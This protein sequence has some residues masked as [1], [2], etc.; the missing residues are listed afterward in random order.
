[1]SVCGLTT[2]L[3]GF[4]FYRFERRQ[5]ENTRNL[6]QA[7]EKLEKEV[8]ERERY[9]TAL[10]NNE[11]E[12]RILFENMEQ[13]VVVQTSETEIISVNPAAEKILGLSKDQ[14]MGRTSFDPRWKAMRENYTDLPGDEHPVSLALR[15]G[16]PVRNMVMGVFNPHLEETRWIMVNATPLFKNGE[17]KPYQV[18]ATFHDI[19]DRKRAE[20]A[21]QESEKRFALFMDH[22]PGVAFIKDS[23]GRYVFLNK[24]L[25]EMPDNIRSAWYGKTNGDLFP[26]DIAKALMKTDQYVLSDQI[27]IQ[28]EEQAGGRVWLSTK[29]PIVSK[30][31]PDM[32]GGISLDITDRKRAEEDR[33]KLEAQLLH[34]QKM[35]ALGELVGGISHDFNNMLQV[36]IGYIQILLMDKDTEH[37]E[38]SPLYEV[39][40]AALSTRKLIRQLMT[41]SRQ[42]ISQLQPVDINYEI[43]KVKTLLERTIPK[44]ID[45][46]LHLEEDVWPINGDPTQLEQVLV[47][48]SINARDAMPEGGQLIFETANVALDEEYCRTHLGTTP[49]DHVLVSVTDSGRGMEK[50]VMSRIF[51]PFFTTKEKERGTGLGLAM[52]FGIVKSHDGEIMCYSEPGHGTTFKIYFPAAE[53]EDHG[54]KSGISENSLKGGS[55]TILLADDDEVLRSMAEKMLTRFGYQVLTAKDGETTLEIYKKHQEDISLVILD[56]IMPGMGGGRCLEELLLFDPQVKILIASGYSMNGLTKGAIEAG[57]RKCLAKPFEIQSLIMTVRDIL[58]SD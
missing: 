1:M 18:F 48:L 55:E 33:K 13:G 42:E 20:E 53:P 27:P 28:I 31:M 58:D 3:L 26:A 10:E 43:K 6:N 8:L 17:D 44:M 45:I 9:A 24:M 4:V 37:P 41:F 39:E 54:L 7:K 23:K 38:Y 29:F 2:L 25:K 14:M 47:N 36:I 49:G 52:V 22:L 11:R 32:L 40:Q 34:A 57:A 16:R 50:E 56:L 15:S 46:E 12:Y 19:T 51:E 21:L 5:T 35:E 30:A